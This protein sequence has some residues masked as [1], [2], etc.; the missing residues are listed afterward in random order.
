M[1]KH[2]KSRR[3]AVC[4]SP[5]GKMFLLQWRGLLLYTCERKAEKSK[6]SKWML[7]NLLPQAMVNFPHSVSL[8]T[9]RHRVV[10]I[11]ANFWTPELDHQHG[12]GTGAWVMLSIKRQQQTRGAAICN[13]ESCLLSPSVAGWTVTIAPCLCHLHWAV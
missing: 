6:C 9:G 7:L 12:E 2:C 11:P 8:N 4:L 1:L 5:T 10:L 3:Q 13:A